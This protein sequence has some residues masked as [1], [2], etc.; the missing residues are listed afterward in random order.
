MSCPSPTAAIAS[1]DGL[2]F[3]RSAASSSKHLIRNMV[4]SRRVGDDDDSISARLMMRLRRSD[5]VDR[6]LRL[7]LRKHRA[8]ALGRL[9]FT[10]SMALVSSPGAGPHRRSHGVILFAVTLLRSGQNGSHLH[11]HSI[12]M[13]SAVGP[14][15]RG[16]VLRLC[17]SSTD[18][19][20][21]PLMIYQD[22]YLYPLATYSPVLP[23]PVDAISSLRSRSPPRRAKPS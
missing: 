10:Q 2:R 21:H 13:R 9:H 18:I 16:R 19:H 15:P 4:R 22:C 12:I 8:P 20:N 17:T 1:L 7:A 11:S 14:Q 23:C 3:S 5:T 6:S